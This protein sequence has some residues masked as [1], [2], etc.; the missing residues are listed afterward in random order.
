MEWGMDQG[1]GMNTEVATTGKRRRG[2]ACAYW[3]AW[4]SER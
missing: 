1:Y 3:T 4:N 2:L